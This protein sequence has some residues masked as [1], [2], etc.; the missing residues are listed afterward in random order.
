M[1]GLAAL[2][3]G[4]CDAVVHHDAAIGQQLADMPEIARE[5]LA[6]HVLEH[7]DAGDTVVLAADL[8]VVLQA[9]LDAIR[10]AGSVYPFSRQFEPVLRQSHTHAAHAEAQG[11]AHHQRPQTQP[12]PSKV[13]RARRSILDRMWS[14][15]F[16]CAV[17]RSSSPFSKQA[18]E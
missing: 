9:D 14:I 12:M 5:I 10:H 16:N 1:R 8:A 3:I 11:S 15:F 13:W 7:A 6:A 2:G 17:A 18:R 4:G